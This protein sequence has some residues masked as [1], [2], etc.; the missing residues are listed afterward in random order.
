MGLILVRVP[1]R[2]GNQRRKQ[3]QNDANDHGREPSEEILDLEDWTILLTSVP[4]RMLSLPDVLV[5]ARLHWQ[6]ER[7]FRLWKED[8]QIDEWCSKK[9]SRFLTEL[10]ATLCAMV[11][12]PWLFHQGC[13]TDPHRRLFQAA[14]LLQR[15][16]NRL[17]VALYEDQVLPV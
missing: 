1:K 9:P 13:W 4:R 16:I 2:V 11:I 5:L 7:L 14:H 15:E 17:M 10:Y 3:M 6:S 8:S 12:Q